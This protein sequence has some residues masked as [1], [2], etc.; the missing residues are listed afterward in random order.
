MCPRLTPAAFGAASC[1]AA[2]IVRAAARRKTRAIVA[3][4]GVNVLGIISKRK[5]SPKKCGVASP[6]PQPEL[7]L[8]RLHE[9]L[10]R[11]GS[12]CEAGLPHGAFEV[13]HLIDS[14]SD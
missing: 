11:E 10:W 2:C 12:R 9:F 14:N 7:E 13:I 8:R 6:R 1:P 4:I 5:F 3:F